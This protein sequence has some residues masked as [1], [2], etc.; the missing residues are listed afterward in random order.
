[1]SS[2]PADTKTV[3]KHEYRDD[4]F[5]LDFYPTLLAPKEAAQ[6]YS[7]LLKTV[8][9]PRAF[10]PGKRCNQTYGDSGVTYEIHWYNSDSVTK[11]VALPWLDC[12]LPIKQLLEAIT[13]QEYNICV[14]QYYPSG[15]VGIKRHRDSEMTPGTTISGISLGA[16]RTLTMER[17]GINVSI[18]LLPGSLYVFNPPTNDYWMHSIEPDLA[19]K[20]PRISLTFRNYKPDKKSL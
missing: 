6:L 15:R 4:K 12:L 19:V 18:P 10:T 2:V 9:W 8:A 20:D 11:R 16:T 13:K 3:E 5:N 7:T 17:R 14:V 1:M